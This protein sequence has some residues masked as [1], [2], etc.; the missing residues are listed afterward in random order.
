MFV[1]DI[2]FIIVLSENESLDLCTLKLDYSF[3]QK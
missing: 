1:Y 2:R 3:H